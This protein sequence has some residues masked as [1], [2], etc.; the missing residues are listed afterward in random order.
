[1]IIPVKCFTC[2]NV[3]ANKYLYYV[4]EVSKLKQMKDEQNYGKHEQGNTLSYGEFQSY[5]DETFPT[6][7][8][9]VQRDFVSRMKDLTLDCFLSAKNTMNPSKRRNCFEFLRLE[10]SVE[11]G[12]RSSFKLMFGLSRRQIGILLRWSKRGPFEVISSIASRNCK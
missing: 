10:P 8:L 2:G 6:L 4:E 1:M 7:N 3:L 5:L 9:D 11:L 12:G